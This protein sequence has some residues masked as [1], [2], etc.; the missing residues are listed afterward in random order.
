MWYARPAL[1]DVR[2]DLQGLASIPISWRDVWVGSAVTALLTSAGHYAIAVYLGRAST[3]STYH[4]A[5]SIVALLLWLYYSAL[6]FLLGAEFC[7]AY[8]LRF[9][10][11]RESHGDRAGLATGLSS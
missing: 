11:L 7:R 3:L 4:A 1:R 5:G 6:I 9:G 8:A 2:D 10:S